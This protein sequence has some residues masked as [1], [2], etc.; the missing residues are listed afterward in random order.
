MKRGHTTAQIELVIFTST[1]GRA[2]W[3][4]IRADEVPAFVKDPDVM[5]RLASG[6]ECMDCAQGSTGSNWYR[7]LPVS[8]IHQAVTVH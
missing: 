2:P 8:E 6:E 7:A 3:H 5:A 4:P 1:T